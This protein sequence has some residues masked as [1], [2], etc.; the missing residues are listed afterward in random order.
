MSH[1]IRIATP[2]VQSLLI[3][4]MFDGQPIS[5][6][7]GFIVLSGRGPMLVT[8]RHNVTGRHQETGKPISKTC[9]VPNELVI[10]HNKNGH[11]GEWLPKREKLYDDDQPR[12]F[13][14]PKFGAAADFVALPLVE[15]SDVQFFPYDPIKS[16]PNMHI[17][18]PQW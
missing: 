15:I 9:A 6:G 12:W 5:T 14:H 11:L 2:S 10:I 7:T 18:Q 1:E 13:E 4:M 16:G 17:G 8:N 3:L